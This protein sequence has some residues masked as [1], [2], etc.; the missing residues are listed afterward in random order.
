VFICG[1]SYLL[2]GA[3][4]AARACVALAAAAILIAGAQA[5]KLPALEDFEVRFAAKLAANPGPF[6]FEVLSS[7]PAIY[8]P[9]VGVA[10]SNVVNLSYIDPPSPFRGPYTAKEKDGFRDR[11]LERLPILERSMREV[12][13][14]TAAAPDFDP[15]P[16]NERVVLG[17]TLFYFTWENSTGLPRQVVM[18]AE[19]GKLLQARRDKLDLATVIQEQKL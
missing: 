8:V 7:T 12:M 19:K 9:G 2:R 15:M 3:R 4:A 14:D 16:P 11:K 6:P 5:I 1:P 17:V 10:L 18:S 13:A